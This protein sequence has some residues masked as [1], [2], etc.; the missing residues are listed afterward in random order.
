MS[1]GSVGHIFAKRLRTDFK[2]HGEVFGEPKGLLKSR[3]PGTS[4]ANILSL[5]RTSSTSWSK[6]MRRPRSSLSSS[7]QPR[8]GYGSQAA[9]RG[10]RQP[11]FG[12]QERENLSMQLIGRA[13]KELNI[14]DD[15]MKAGIE[16]CQASQADP[17][18]APRMTS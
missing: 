16:T 13:K 10:E 14:F 1:P 3:W 7:W 17:S 6:I 18:F 2:R 12:S 8:D 11:V 9:S 4:Y 15:E 5:Q